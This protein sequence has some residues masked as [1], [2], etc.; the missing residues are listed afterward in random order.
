MRFPVSQPMFGR[1]LLWVLSLG[2]GLWLVGI[3]GAH[4]AQTTAELHPRILAEHQ[5]VYDNLEVHPQGLF[6]LRR[7]DSVVTATVSSLGSAV[8]YAARQQPEVLFRVPVGF[9]PAETAVREVQGWPLQPDGRPDPTVRVP[10][11]FKVQIAPNGEVRYQ[12]GPELD[13]VGY[14]AY[15]LVISWY[16]PDFTGPYRNQ[17][18]H[19][20]SRVALQRRGQRVTGVFTT[21][22]SPVQHYARPAPAV[23]FTLP[24][25]YRPVQ[26]EVIWV[27]GARPVDR[28]GQILGDEG[29]RR[30][31]HMRVDPSGAV[32]YVNDGRM[33][34]VDYLAYAVEAT[35][36]TEAEPLQAVNTTWIRETNPR[37]ARPPLVAGE[38]F[39]Q[40][41]LAGLADLLA[42][43]VRNP[44]DTRTCLTLTWP[45][46]AAQERL[47]RAL[48][49]EDSLLWHRDPPT[50]ALVRPTI[51]WNE[52]GQVT[53][54]QLSGLGLLGHLPP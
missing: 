52:A 42:S 15:V 50:P 7:Q 40:R 22:R 51:T 30:T 24:E 19:Q 49:A 44:E 29:D 17:A 3:P 41:H 9:R 4:W 33:D 10:R 46:Q 53:H 2:L 23:L 36:T 5:G 38:M 43:L 47:R 27:T 1:R 35:W 6:H 13:D 20:D 26:P 45:E 32:R 14:L 8:Q 21:Q 18:E 34:Q 25:G 12:D 54:L 48:G 11:R 16:T 37:A 31:F 39:C 28:A